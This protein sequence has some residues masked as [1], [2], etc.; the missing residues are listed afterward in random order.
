[1]SSEQ[2]GK[3]GQR[4]PWA[5]SFTGAGAPDYLRYHD[6]EWGVPSHDERHLFEM[7]ILEGAQAGLSWATILARR[8]HYRA[9]LDNFDAE[10]VAR[11]DD[12]KLAQLLANARIIRNRLKLTSTIANARACLRLREAGGGLD[13][14]L[15][16]YVDGRPIDN[17]WRHLEQIPASTALSTRISKDMK[18]AGFSFVGPTV[19][20]AYMQGVGLVNDHLV[21]CPR[22]A[23]CA[24]LAKA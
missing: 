16:R 22:H 17:R 23:A 11:Y 12:R 5:G 8:E 1:M 18:K 6:E 20:Y 3:T 15:W 24:A 21:T 2:A 9:A 7:L 10:K 14:F 4:C 19:V 13:A